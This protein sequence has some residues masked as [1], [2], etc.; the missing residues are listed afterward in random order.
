VHRN[1]KVWGIVPAAGAAGAILSMASAAAAG[2]VILDMRIISA[3]V[4][5][6]AGPT[7]DYRIS[8]FEITNAQFTA[9]LNDALANL[10]NER[11]QYMYFDTDTGNV[12]VNSSQ[13][14]AQGAGAGP[15]ATLLFSADASGHITYDNSDGT[16]AVEQ[17]F[18][19]HPA[20]GMSWYGA[21]KFC[22]WLT[23]QAGIRS[24]QRCYTEA[25]SDNLSGWHPVTISDSAWLARDLSADERLSLVS[26]YVGYRL[27]MD[28]GSLQADS[29]NEWYKAAS[30]DLAAPDT[31]RVSPL[32]R[33]IQ[34]DHWIY[35]FGRDTLGGQDANY[36]ESG[37]PFDNGTTPI[38]FFDGT[39][40]N[41]GGNGTVGSGIEFQS[42]T[43][44]NPFGLFD[45][46]GNVW[47][48]VQDQPPGDPVLRRCRG[49]GSRS[50]GFFVEN[51]FATSDVPRAAHAWLGLRVVQ[52]D[53]HL[54]PL[55]EPA[56][57]AEFSGPIGGPFISSP[58]PVVYTLTSRSP[59]PLDWEVTANV[60]WVEILN[61]QGESNASGTLP[62]FARV[63][64]TVA[65]NDGAAP[66]QPGQ[67]SATLTFQAG[68]TPFP[69]RSV[70]LIV[71]DQL[72]VEPGTGLLSAGPHGGPFFPAEQPYTLTN[73]TDEGLYFCVCATQPWVLVDGLSRICGSGSAVCG[74]VAPGLSNTVNVSLKTSGEDGVNSLPAGEIH[75]AIVEFE[76]QVTGAK[77]TREVRVSVG[78]SPLT[79][80]M[81]I[82]PAQAIQ[83]DGPEHSYRISFYEITNAQF[84]TFLNDALFNTTNERGAY[85][86][87]VT[88]TG[89]VSEH[90]DVYIHTSET[91][92]LGTTGAGTLM[93]DASDGGGIT[94][95]HGQYC[96]EPGTEDE[97][98]V[99][100]SW[101]GALKFCNW[102]T[103]RQ[104][105][106]PSQRV[107]TEGPTP[108]NW[109]P[110]VVEASQ[111][112]VRDL[113]DAER[114]ALIADYTGYRL[115]M[116][117]G[118]REASLFNEWYKTAA[119]DQQAPFGNTMNATAD[120][121]ASCDETSESSD[122]WWK[123]TP[124][125]GGTLTI[126]L[127]ADPRNVHSLSVHT[128]CPGSA[129]NELACDATG[130]IDLPVYANKTYWI[131]VAA[132]SAEGGPF[133]L[134]LEGPACTAEPMP[135]QDDCHNAPPACPGAAGVNRLYGFGKD[136]LTGA[137]ANFRGS[138]DPFDNWLTPAGWFD[139]LNRV[140]GGRTLTN[141]TDNS[142]GLYDMCGNA[143][144]WMQDQ[145]GDATLRATRGGH[146]QNT[147]GSSLL[148]N[149]ERESDFAD[150][151]RAITGFRVAQTQYSTSITVTAD[152]DPDWTGS[153]AS[154]GPVGGPYAHV[155]NTFTWT[156]DHESSV[157]V[158]ANPYR[159]CADVDWLSLNEKAACVEGLLA[160]DDLAAPVAIDVSFNEAADELRASPE[161]AITM[162]TVP[163]IEAQPDG[164]RYSYRIATFETTN[165][166]YARF[167]NN[168]VA[169]P[170]NA[171][172][173]YMYFDTATGH[174][175]INSSQTG[176]QGTG[177]GSRTTML[178]NA[179][180]NTHIIFDEVE[181]TYIAE[182]GYEK[183]PVTGVSWFGA[184]KYCNWLSIDA[185]LGTS[186]RAYTEGP[187][188]GD[189]HPV[190]I[191][192]CNW[193]GTEDT[194]DNAAPLIGTRDLNRRER[195]A[196]VD[197]YAG[198]RLPMDNEAGAASPFNEW[199]K[200]AAWDNAT[201]VNHDYGF[202]RDLADG[203]SWTDA[204]CADSGDP[205]EPDTTPV[206]FYDGSRYNDG[207]GGDEDPIGDGSEFQTDADENRYGLY[208][209]C[210]NVAEWMQDVG[211]LVGERGTRGGHV[212]NA[213]TSPLLRAD[214][215]DSL[216]AHATL[217]HV[218]FRI[219]Q[220]KLDRIANLTFTDVG[221]GKVITHRVRLL[222]RE[223]MTVTPDG[224]FE[225]AGLATGPFSNDRQEY[226]LISASDMDV[227][228]QVTITQ[229]GPRWLNVN[230]GA[231]ASGV[232]V[233]QVPAFVTIEAN[234][235]A[236]T[237]LPGTYSASAHFTNMTT[238][239]VASRKFTLDVTE[240][241]DISCRV[242]PT[243][244]CSDDAFEVTSTW[245]VDP[246]PSSKTYALANLLNTELRYSVTHAPVWIT[247]DDGSPVTGVLQPAGDP[248][249]EDT[250]DVTAMTNDGLSA[251]DIGVYE[252]ETITFRN[253]TV[254]SEVPVAVRLTVRDPLDIAPPDATPESDFE[255]TGGFGGPFA[256]ASGDTY[257]I[258][259]LA[260]FSIDYVVTADVDWLDIN[261][262]SSVSDTL[263]PGFAHEIQLAINDE[264][265]SFNGGVYPAR[266]SFADLAS[267]HTQTRTVTLVIGGNLS[268]TPL[269]DY[270]VFGPAGGPFLP[271]AHAYTL[272][273][274]AGSADLS[275]YVT[276]DPPTSWILIDGQ[277]SAEGSLPRGGSV[278]VVISID[279]GAASGMPEGEHSTVVMFDDGVAETEPVTRTVTL[280]V[281]QPAFDVDE[282]LMSATDHQP[283]GPRYSYMMNASHITNEE[284][285]AFLNDTSRN[286][287]TPR[288]QY[289]FFDTVTGDVYVNNSQTGE[290][291]DDPGPRD[292]LMFS[293]GVAGRITYLGTAQGYAVY[294]GS[295]DYSRHPVVGVS[296]YGALKFCNWLTIDQG[297]PP[298]YRCYT[299]DVDSRVTGWHPVTLATSVWSARDL[300]DAE[301]MDLVLSCRGYRLPMDDGYL[302]ADASSDQADDYNEWYK[303]GAWDGLAQ[304]NHDYG[305]GR[306]VEDGIDG[307]DA[308]YLDSGDP[309]DN[310][311][312][313]VG[314]YDGTS[315]G[316][317]FQT[318]ADANA[319]GL[320][321]MT[322]N[323]LEWMQ[324]Q[325]TDAAGGVNFRT[326][327]GGSFNHARGSGSLILT[328]RVGFEPFHT[329]DQIGFRVVRTIATPNGDFN[330]DGI[331][332]L[333]DFAGFVDHLSGPGAPIGPSTTVFDLETDGDIDL[334]DFAAFQ[335]MFAES[336]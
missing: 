108:Q 209:A 42:R 46:C 102:L 164:P 187:N 261:G 68:Q 124:I 247:L 110:V 126:E 331:I 169:N 308:N 123:Y 40:Y 79:I 289:M 193:W 16:Y 276:T 28:G 119:W 109:H 249:G 140:D 232:L 158:C 168:A 239:H 220:S 134:E 2:P 71:S 97:P 271:S 293:P 131:R 155:E 107:Y 83:P 335:N 26:D 280:H 266:V 214:T 286:L 234:N 212:Q 148:K 166:E 52:S 310:G 100:V 180:V 254:G 12:Y 299:E 77:A 172:G 72:T 33:A 25:A 240:P 87:H 146:W 73:N 159:A 322:G 81:A 196:L 191:S 43:D 10:E 18:A 320:F 295:V 125:A 170:G 11:G 98:V 99:G 297:M 69:T 86:A 301:R 237:L 162:S 154:A 231:S 80:D 150:S 282:K 281:I 34:P 227:N 279:T 9:F 250:I 210:G 313:P 243:D 177:A 30:F 95:A 182:E 4:A 62:P 44:Q 188:P 284:F 307:A 23:L 238:G 104:G 300:N 167:L 303:A 211:A 256:S 183:H 32:G 235:T 118:V 215:R 133:A 246:E 85:M 298:D 287:D 88:D 113:D 142:F 330:L 222:L 161:P 91:G 184:L 233:S 156:I 257:T 236:R 173:Q 206:G 253:G 317:S 122:V 269:E 84:A 181:R 311:T 326:L 120:G 141:D 129:C 132:D 82:V 144:E 143:S 244:D 21:A 291:G 138:G 327:R 225:A 333:E 45:M 149:A 314:Y 332:N 259:D 309:F 96:V 76:D 201:G 171:R 94:F 268:V 117:D 260:D 64:V 63:T 41:P 130:L 7:Y 49:G 198:Y 321:D 241:L 190:T 207:T 229:A 39:L 165:E 285:V 3:D 262:E 37:D 185:G 78:L 179:A 176:G 59:D 5:E 304:R 323:V 270:E 296:W 14:G 47:E 106:A 318:R 65:V 66:S 305:F 251:L 75:D 213:D 160:P 24:E 116:D 208:D 137:D 186:Q 195:L 90:G 325:F 319:F 224:G 272:T 115:P 55:V 302:N 226:T 264:A 50:P 336:P 278:A 56:E 216:S 217:P 58:D 92:A 294:T 204:N 13:V 248:E 265:N 135:P 283:N 324:G 189:W 53:P 157:A 54:P 31:V 127:T 230:G 93:F 48:W 199:Y 334:G 290:A 194:T 315:H 267:G 128:D 89:D 242:T 147:V 29:Y 57:S 252:N 178:F 27:P 153:C 277:S 273:N 61:P 228:W 17:G 245:G 112:A 274:A 151:T 22:N 15:L 111:W 20:A 200:A 145:G 175:Y 8:T 312:T 38:G 70:E 136:E 258:T 288:G 74:N 19:V 139:G 292:T 67:Y 218:G 6:P 203:F 192:T 263:L 219:A 205:F 197:G 36:L 152:C 1:G 60:D 163:A 329:H 306:D 316:G 114:Q 174:V 103:V 328:Y 202:G 51:T 121:S 275:W 223:P 255:W 105:M 221:T 101:Y 35:G